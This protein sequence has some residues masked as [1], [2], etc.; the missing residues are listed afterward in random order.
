MKTKKLSRLQKVA[1][2][3]KSPRIAFSTS[4][5]IFVVSHMRSRSSALSHVLGSHP[6]IVGHGE[7]LRGYGS[8]VDTAISRI[9]LNA[10]R[11]H[12]YF[13]DKLLHNYA[14]LDDSLLTSSNNKILFLLREPIAAAQSFVRLYRTEK[15]TCQ[16]SDEEIH[17]DYAEY[18][19]QRMP[20]LVAMAKKIGERAR[21]LDSD[22]LLDQ[23]GETLDS[24]TEFL[25]LSSPLKSEFNLFPD[26]EST[27]HGD[28]TGGLRSKKLQ[29]VTHSNSTEVE[30][31]LCQQLTQT[32]E[33]TKESIENFVPGLLPVK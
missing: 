11:Q 22:R 30:Q 2:L 7:L 16:R 32:Y 28:T 29:S 13:H 12:S 1:I 10:T 21:V 17:G 14:W 24:L 27:G 23:P 20:T 19:Q 25:Q 6:Q 26:S 8:W 31:G 5:A 18:Y 4:R 9:E 15:P 33:A 3:I